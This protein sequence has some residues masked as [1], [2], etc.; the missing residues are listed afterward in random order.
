VRAVPHLCGFYPGICLTTE[1]KGR[2]NLEQ[3]KISVRKNLKHG[4]T[5]S[6]FQVNA[7]SQLN[8]CINSTI[9]DAQ[10]ARSITNYKLLKTNAAMWNNKA[11]RNSQLTPKYVK[12]K[13]IQH[14]DERISKE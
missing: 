11:C 7:H 13:I 8:I 9:A 3:G 14:H 5:S 12:Q 6:I 4:K 1:E 10:Q 2:K